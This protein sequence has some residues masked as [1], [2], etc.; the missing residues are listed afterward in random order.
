MKIIALNCIFACIMMSCNTHDDTTSAEGDN[1]QTIK[2]KMNRFYLNDKFDSSIK[3]LNVLIAAD[4]LNGEYFFKRGYS[5]G[6]IDNREQAIADFQK[7]I[8]LHYRVSD[9][10]LNIGNRYMFR[11][12]SLALYN[13]KKS[14]EANPANQKA[15]IQLQLCEKVLRDKKGRK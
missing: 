10:Y 12:D 13:Y 4:S 15:A 2:A 7:A 3:Y 11:N 9:A 1:T 5:F 8:Q 6:Q 14:L